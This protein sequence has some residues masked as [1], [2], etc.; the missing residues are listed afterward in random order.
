M[1]LVY[2]ARVTPPQRV[3]TLCRSIGAAGVAEVVVA[4]NFA[5]G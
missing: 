2:D 3:E 4:E 5:Q 1:L